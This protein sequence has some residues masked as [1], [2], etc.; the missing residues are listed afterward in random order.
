VILGFTGSRDGMTEAQH[1]EI[2][3]LIEEWKPAEGH[4]GDCVGADEQF[5]SI[6]A[7]RKIKR[8]IHPPINETLRAFCRGDLVMRPAGYMQRDRWIVRSTNQLLATPRSKNDLSKSGTW[9]TIRFCR[10]LGKKV[11]IVFPDGS[12]SE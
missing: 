9:F 5:D 8:V 2:L 4:H 6:L 7:E 1:A 12:H 3:K 10:Q 11:H